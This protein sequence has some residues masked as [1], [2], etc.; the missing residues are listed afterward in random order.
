MTKKIIFFRTTIF[1]KNT[2]RQSLYRIFSLAYPDKVLIDQD[3]SIDEFTEE[4]FEETSEEIREA[5]T[6]I[7]SDADTKNMEFSIESQSTK[8]LHNTKVKMAGDKKILQNLESLIGKALIPQ[9]ENNAKDK[10]N[11]DSQ[12]K[13]KDSDKAKKLQK[14][15]INALKGS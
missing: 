2:I 8:P 14:L 13:T 11:S 10:M 3:E 7:E 15:L 5:F 1:S 9:N 12:V 6:F 4:Y